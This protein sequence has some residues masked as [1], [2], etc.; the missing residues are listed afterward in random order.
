MKQRKRSFLLFTLCIAAVFGA[1]TWLTSQLLTYEQKEQQARQAEFNGSQRRTALWRMD[2]ALGIFLTQEAARPYFEYFSFYEPTQAYTRLLTVACDVN[3]PSPLLMSEPE[4]C[5]LHFQIKQG[6]LTTPRAPL[7]AVQK[8]EAIRTIMTEGDWKEANTKREQLEMMLPVNQLPSLAQRAARE[9][10]IADDHP[11]VA[12]TD[13]RSNSEPQPFRVNT[14]EWYVRQQTMSR[15]MRSAQDN[16]VQSER[17]GHDKEIDTTLLAPYWVKTG[18]TEPELFLLRNVRINGEEIVQG[19]WLDWPRLRA[20]L[21]ASISDLL[22][23]ASLEPEYAPARHPEH[24]IAGIRATLVTD[25]VPLASISGLT[26]LRKSLVIAWCAVLVALTAIGIV[27]HASME[28]GER[29]GRFVSAVTHELRTPLTTFC[30]YSEMLADGMVRDEGAKREYLITLKR[31]AQRLAKIVENVLCYA[32][33]SEVRPLARIED[34]EASDLLARTLPSLERRAAESAMQLVVD[35]D[36]ARDAIL[37]VDPQTIE[38]ILLNLVENACRYAVDHAPDG[39]APD[40]RIH[41]HASTLGDEVR[42]V[43]ADHGPGVPR[44]L[45][46]KLFRAFNRVGRETNNA[47]PGLGLGL[48][49]SRGL[50]RSLGGDL[51]LLD[52]SPI[53]P[54]AAFELRIPAETARSMVPA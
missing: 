54:G 12:S 53:A 30:L 10:G 28:L 20:S 2:S 42:I 34:I 15:A 16:V 39:G 7:D 17:H 19:V 31:E 26:P 29:R 23:S 38:R 4:F 52:H 33:L 13:S 46:H 48:S 21:L 43:V 8:M 37:H 18:A 49:L 40:H 35:T 44:E 32:R 11:A 41:L 45:R 6:V 27:L 5:R 1:M 51:I 14:P 47:A 22:P 24:T 50:A 9:R 36:A 25:E 3:E